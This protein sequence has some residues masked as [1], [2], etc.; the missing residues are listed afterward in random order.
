V[1]VCIQAANLGSG[2]VLARALGPVDRGEL[3][4][5][6][7]WPTLIAGLGVLGVSDAVVYLVGKD[8]DRSADLLSGSLLVGIIQ[9]VLLLGVGWLLVPYVL[10]GKP[11]DVVNASLF[12]LWFVPLALLT[13]YLLALLQGR[14]FLAPFNLARASVHIFYTGALLCLWLIHGVTIRAALGATLAASCVTLLL[15]FWFVVKRV[16]LRPHLSRTVIRSLLTYGAKL[17]IGNVATIVVQRADLLALILL[18]P[19]A[20]LGQYVV[21]SAI[22]MGAGLIPTAASLVLFPTFSNH[23]QDDLPRSV[24]RFLMVAGGFTVVAGPVLTLLLPW[25]LPFLFGAAYASAVPTSMILVLAYLIRGW[26]QMFFS[27]LRGTGHALSASTGELGG[28]VVMIVLLALLVPRYEGSGAAVSVLFGACAT[29]T[30]VVLKTLTASRLTAQ[31]LIAYWS[32]D[33]AHLIK[34]VR[35][36]SSKGS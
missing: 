35:V 9:S 3:A 2:V 17:H 28:L 24:A 4:I 1:S 20:V 15:T 13:G 27:I 7:L 8:G 33:V 30:W 18:V 11:A 5:A 25:T 16:P 32:S 22:G 6:M 34:L 19:A 14:L 21:A 29:L 12:Y 26:N 31:L 23:E 10:A 36:P